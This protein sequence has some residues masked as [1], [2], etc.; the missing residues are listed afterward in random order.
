MATPEEKIKLLTEDLYKLELING[1]HVKAS[2]EPQINNKISKQN[3][4]LDTLARLLKEKNDVCLAVCY[5]NGRLLIASNR[6]KATYAEN[7]LLALQKFAK[8]ESPSFEDY[9]DLMKLIVKRKIFLS[10][11]EEE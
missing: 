7:Y 3:K 6:E 8:K 10:L 5:H 4:Y 11:E 1:V 9:K 2:I